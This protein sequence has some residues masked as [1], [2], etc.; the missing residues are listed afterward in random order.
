MFNFYFKT[1]DSPSALYKLG[2]I[3]TCK[4]RERRK[5]AVPEV[6]GGDWFRE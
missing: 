3:K 6:S 2:N 4:L 5:Q 1:Y